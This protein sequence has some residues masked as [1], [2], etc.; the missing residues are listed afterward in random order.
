MPNRFFK[1]HFLAFS[2][3]FSCV[4]HSDCFE[5]AG[6]YYGIDP[7]YLRAIAWQES[8]FKHNAINKN[9]DG[10]I[11]VGIMQINT[12]TLKSIKREYPNLTKDRLLNE[13]CLN[14]FVGGMLLKRNFNVYGKK[15]L[16]VGM[17]NAGMRNSDKVIQNRYNYASKINKHYQDLKSGKIERIAIH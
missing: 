7:D 12:T 14:I 15:W 5:S 16:S 1:K 11:D 4:A 10:S 2:L 13:P 6:K 8:R 3:L 9:Y 17:Y